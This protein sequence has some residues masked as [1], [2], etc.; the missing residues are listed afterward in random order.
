MR[1]KLPRLYKYTKN[2]KCYNGPIDALRTVY[3]EEGI[4]GYFK[5]TKVAIFTVPIFYSLYFP[6]YEKSKIYFATKLYNDKFK[7]NAAVYTLSSASSAII[8]DIFTN[9]MWV[10]RVRHQTEFL[11]SGSQTGDSFN[12]PK[13]IKQLYKD[14]IIQP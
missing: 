10:V 11:F 8:C 4:R 5:G 12:V 6:I 3:R 9:P 14:V 7:M 2:K 13:A 1:S